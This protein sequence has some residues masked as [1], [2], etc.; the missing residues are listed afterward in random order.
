[1]KTSTEHINDLNDLAVGES[2][3][4]NFDPMSELG[5]WKDVVAYPNYQINNEG[6]FMNKR[7]LK[8]LKHFRHKDSNKPAVT[9][10]RNGKGDVLDVDFLLKDHFGI[11]ATL[12]HV[13]YFSHTLTEILP[14]KAKTKTKKKQTQTDPIWDTI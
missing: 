14:P 8:M 11:D 2:L 12:P 1:M 6:A 10:Y 9:L 4:F 7:T 5:E 3:E 13:N